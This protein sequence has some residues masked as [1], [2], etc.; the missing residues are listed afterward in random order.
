M[1]RGGSF[2]FGSFAQVAGRLAPALRLGRDAIP[3]LRR[4][5]SDEPDPGARR[6]M[7]VLLCSFGEAAAIGALATGDPDVTIPAELGPL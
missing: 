2:R 7:V 6:H 5:A 1:T 4:L 3:A